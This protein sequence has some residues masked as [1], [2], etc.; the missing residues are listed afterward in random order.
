MNQ[1]EYRAALGRF[2]LSGDIVF[3]SIET[4]SGGQ[5]S[6]LAFACLG[7]Q[8]VVNLFDTNEV[9]FLAQLSDS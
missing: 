5:K 4:L 8:K 7:L 6:R 9:M 2:G 1:E 3:Q